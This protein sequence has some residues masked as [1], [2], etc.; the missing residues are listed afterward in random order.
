MTIIIYRNPAT[1]KS[2]GEWYMFKRYAA[3]FTAI[4]LMI[5]MFP[6][7]LM[8]K[9]H[10]YQNNSYFNDLK[11]GL[12]TMSST[13]I[14]ITLGGEYTLNGQ[15]Y[16]SGTIFNLGIS[17][18]SITLNGVAQDQISIVPSNKTS[19]LTL[20][21]GTLSY[22]YMGSF[23]IKMFNGKLLPINYL[24]M[25]NYLKG[26]VGYEM[27]DSFPMES[28][29]AQA[30]AA[31]NYAL[32]RIGYEAA[33][34]YDFDDT[35]NYQVYKG[36]DANYKNV[37]NAVDQT[38]GQVLLYNERL[39]ETLYSAWHGGVSENSENVWGNTVPYLRSVVDTFESDP[40]PN[41]NRVLTNAQIQSTLT[42][43][44]YLSLGDTFVKLDLN[45]IT[46]YASGRVSNINIIY[47]NSSGI[48]L[49]KSVIR[50]STRTFLGLPSNMYNVTYDAVAGAY[51]FSGKGYGHGLGM[52]QIGAK[53]RALAGQTYEQ[54][55]KFY[56]QGTYLQNLVAKASLG[57]VIQSSSSLL[58]GNTVSFNASATGGSGYGYLFKYVVKNGTNVVFTRDYDGSST[59]DFTPV[60]EGSFT[61]EAYVKDKFSALDFDDKKELTFIVYG[62]PSL[63]NLTLSKTQVFV[64]EPVTADVSIQ[65][66]SGSSLYKYEI[67]KDGSI[68]STRDFSSDKQFTFTPSQSGSYVV[69]SYVKDALSTKAFDIETSKNISVYDYLTIASLTKDSEDVITGDTVS[70]STSVSGGSGNGVSY[71]Y[72]VMQ[73]GQTISTRDFSSISTFTFTPDAAGFFE[74]T[75][76]AVDALSGKEYDAASNMSFE[77]KDR[78][79]ITSLT[80]DKSTAFANSTITVNASATKTDA[81]YKFVVSKDNAVVLIQDYS[82]LSSLSFTAALA[83]NYTV[84]AYAKDGLSLKEYDDEK[85]I[86]IVVYE[87]ASMELTASS[88]STTLGTTVNYSISAIKG[89]GSNEYRF[90][91]MKDNILV[92]DS[93]YS[94]SNTFSFTPLE[95]GSYQVIGYVKD[96]LSGNEFD[97]E[98]SLTLTVTNPQLSA[99]T[100]AGSFYEGKPVNFTASNSEN[101]A[102]GFSYRYEVYNGVNLVA[103]NSFSE[104]GIFNFTPS[105]PGTYSI[106]VYGK[107][108]LSTN[109]YDGV[110]EFN[111]TISSKPL[112][113]SILPLK[114]GMKNNDVV[115][116][117]NALV[118][119]GY[120]V[121]GDASGY[122]GTKTK[123]AVTSF[124]RSR[125]LS[126]DGIVG[127]MT[128]KALND[129][130]I[131]KAGVKTLTF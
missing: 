21:S 123:N 18:T 48:E 59:L 121:A 35:I 110:K 70:F 53:N 8:Q 75:V 126:A 17:G 116:L 51:T 37:I 13:S 108:S 39:V 58:L 124:Q 82:A 115:S 1:Q 47:K 81:L 98:S 41:G 63:S 5:N 87:A 119:L 44:G 117:Q 73:N 65:G 83:G 6:V 33:K 29:K 4:F 40:W 112:Y 55:L 129:A 104:S 125:G 68:I 118:K 114:Y 74:V 79:S 12:T 86:A 3:I 54:I 109:A 76:Y 7:M 38:R 93:G 96:L 42:S 91:V 32:S 127:S 30:I 84:T 92:K 88:S 15:V 43:K 100:A 62:A 89:S 101:K 61:V 45:S 16:P 46:K 9:V 97:A 102:S 131:E 130:L 31:R 57:S 72:V 25:E 10:A 105:V 66:G 90:V 26:V 85:N 95:Y 28:L 14:T 50:D 36:Y 120:S 27:S 2:Q 56:Y 80:A 103:S 20:K 24:D 122:F 107:D 23:L 22:K 71:K 94:T 106:K 64:N 34:G 111:I 69:N 99:V 19:L 11:V 49:T 113:L 78:V 52:S 128:Y 77:V 67:I 60:T